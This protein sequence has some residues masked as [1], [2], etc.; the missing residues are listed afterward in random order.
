MSGN[1]GSSGATIAWGAGG[2]EDDCLRVSIDAA[3]DPPDPDEDFE[4]GNEYEVVLISNGT[5]ETIQVLTPAGQVVGA[6]RP[7]QALLRCLR[8]AVDFTATVIAVNQG[9]VIVR[10]RARA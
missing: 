3:L 2:D 6:V 10:V 5:I 4:L 8:K 9:E 7:H 1:G